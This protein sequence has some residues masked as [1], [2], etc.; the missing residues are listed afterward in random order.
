MFLCFDCCERC[1]CEH[2]RTGLR[3]DMRSF[4]YLGSHLGTQLGAKSPGPVLVL[5]LATGEMSRLLPSAA[6][7]LTVSPARGGLRVPAS[8]SACHRSFCFQPLAGRFG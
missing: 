2:S 8:P 6:T 3:V 1:G 4:I 7:R 5:C